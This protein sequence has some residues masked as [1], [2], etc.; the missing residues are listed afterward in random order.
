MYK[1]DRIRHGNT[2]RYY[3]ARNADIRK[4]TANIVIPSQTPNSYLPVRLSL[5]KEEM[6][7]ILEHTQTFAD[8]T[9]HVIKVDQSVDVNWFKDKGVTNKQP[10][11]YGGGDAQSDDY[12]QTKNKVTCYEPTSI[13][14]RPAKEPI[15]IYAPIDKHD[16]RLFQPMRKRAPKPCECCFQKEGRIW[17]L[18]GTGKKSKNKNKGMRRLIGK[19]QAEIMA[20]LTH[21]K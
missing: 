14:K 13:L 1:D 16:Y 20:D 4:K 6:W 2:Q 11:G 12:I 9:G 10:W 3:P 5:N 8:E 7:K 17:M 19:E 21:T 15:T 18:R